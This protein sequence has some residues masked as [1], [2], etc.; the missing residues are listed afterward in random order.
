[1]KGNKKEQIKNILLTLNFK[2]MKKLFLFLVL[3]VGV[4]SLHAQSYY[5]KVEYGRMK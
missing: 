2:V 4:M 5:K 3:L 1:M